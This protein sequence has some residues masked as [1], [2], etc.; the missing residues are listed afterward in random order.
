MLRERQC[1][2]GAA[3]GAA[4]LRTVL[5][6]GQAPGSHCEPLPISRKNKGDPRELHSSC[7]A[8]K[9][10]FTLGLSFPLRTRGLNPHCKEI[11]VVTVGG[12]MVS[13]EKQGLDLRTGPDLRPT[14]Q[15]L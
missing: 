14:C 11:K 9:G 13:R 10:L 1:R 6:S 4:L 8:E 7:R 3:G 12:S 15:K 2:A 5:D